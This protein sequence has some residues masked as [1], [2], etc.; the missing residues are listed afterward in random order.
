MKNL[1]IL[2]AGALLSAC[3]ISSDKFD[4]KYED[5]YCDW[6]VDCEI[7]EDT[8]TCQD[9]VGEVD[10]S[11]CEYDADAAKTCLQNLK[12]GTCPD[13]DSQFVPSGCETVYTCEGGDDSDAE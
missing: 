9:L 6:A 8:A 5:G 12:D 7:F 11:D 1:V 3:S 4:E 10:T 2:V 13:S